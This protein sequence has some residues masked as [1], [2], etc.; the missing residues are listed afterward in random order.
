MKKLALS[1]AGAVLAF[2]FAAPLHAQINGGVDS[3][4]SIGGCV[5]SPENPTA[6]LALVGGVGALAAQLRGRCKARLHKE[7]Q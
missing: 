2:T 7:K 1:L 3:G 4:D 6:I 5:S